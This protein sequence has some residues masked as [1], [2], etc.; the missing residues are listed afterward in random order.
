MIETLRQIFQPSTP[1]SASIP[2][3]F[4]YVFAGILG[5]VLGSFYFATAT[6][7]SYFFYSDSRR[8]YRGDN[9]RRWKEFF[10]RPSFCMNC[11]T[12]IS[13]LHLLPIFGWFLARGQCQ[14]CGT[15]ISPLHLAAE[16]YPGLL[17]PG[18]LY[19][20][21]SWPVA[22][23][24][25]L[26]CGHLIISIVTDARHFM[27]D[28]ENTAF[29]YLW[30][31]ILTY[32]RWTDETWLPLA[33]M[34]GTLAIFLLLYLISQ[35]SIQGLGFGDIP[36]AGAVSLFMG[37]P[38]CMP[39]FVLAA[40]GSIFY[41]MVIKRSREA[42]APFGACLGLATMAILPIRVLYLLYAAP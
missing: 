6:R 42:A 17:L 25:T 15:R 28:H 30:A 4:A 3:A 11:E 12:P 1:E 24:Y 32:L 40:S 13:R 26:F 36:L 35:K 9:R 39:V 5:L 7:V 14:A 34:G 37:F 31:G 18:L 10:A 23:F 27:L 22:F 41:T 16:L 20:G 21:Y 8:Q 2:I 38:D 29:L 19:A 33:A